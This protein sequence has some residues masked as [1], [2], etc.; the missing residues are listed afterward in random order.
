MDLGPN[1]AVTSPVVPADSA[2]HHHACVCR[3]V[4]VRRGVT[5]TIAFDCVL[6]VPY[7]TN[8][9]IS[10]DPDSTSDPIF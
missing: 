2:S 9:K 3:A 7:S 8:V 4:A 6:R 10:R 5:T 1:I